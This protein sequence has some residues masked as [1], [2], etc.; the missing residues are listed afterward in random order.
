MRTL[1]RKAGREAE[2]EVDSA[3][4]SSYHRGELADERMRRMLQT[5]ISHYAPFPSG[6]YG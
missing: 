6:V 5:G 4:I 2:F 3:G 1:I